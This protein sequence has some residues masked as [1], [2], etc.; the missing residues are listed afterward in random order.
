MESKA[1]LTLV[2]VRQFSMGGVACKKI[3]TVFIRQPCEGLQAEVICFMAWVAQKNFFSNILRKEL[4]VFSAVF[5]MFF[6]PTI[7]R[8][9]SMQFFLPF[10]GRL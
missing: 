7:R 6:E 4:N 10:L 5:F 3:D 9:I 2:T 1:N 8:T